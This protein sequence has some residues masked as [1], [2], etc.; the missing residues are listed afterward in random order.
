MLMVDLSTVNRVVKD[1]EPSTYYLKLGP[2][3]DVAQLKRYLEARADS[4]L[5]LV[6]MGQTLPSTVA[7]LQYAIYVLA[8]ILIGIALVNVFN[9]SMMAMQEKRRQIG[10]LKVVGM[11][12]AQ[13]MTM[14]HTNAGALGLIAT[15]CG[16]PLGLV[17]AKLLLA[18]LS[19]TY[20]FGEVDV[21]MNAAYLLM[22][23]PAMVG[24]SMLGSLVPGWQ[25]ARLTIVSVLREE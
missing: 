17:F 18:G 21:V 16:I 15:C 8:A 10:V 13:V 19:R 12:P 4:D 23:P 25:A 14:V 24:V 6:L 11:T 7:Y 1:V 22:L 20:G 5:S 3:T 2:G 9:T